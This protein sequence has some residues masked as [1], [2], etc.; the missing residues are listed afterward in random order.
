MH[1]NNKSAFAPVKD[2]PDWSNKGHEEAMI[3]QLISIN[4]AETGKDAKQADFKLSSDD[5]RC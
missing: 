1:S 5:W 4:L 3:S 2:K